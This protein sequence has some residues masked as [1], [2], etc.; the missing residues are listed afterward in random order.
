MGSGV[1]SLDDLEGAAEQVCVHPEHDRLDG[2]AE[3]TQAEERRGQAAEPE[4]G[5]FLRG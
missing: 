4:A 2:E 1:T 5:T 3:D